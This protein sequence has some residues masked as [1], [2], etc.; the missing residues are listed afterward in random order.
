MP[1]KSLLFNPQE[2]KRFYY[3]IL[4]LENYSLE[5]INQ[6]QTGGKHIL[7]DIN[8]HYYRSRESGM[9]E[10]YRRMSLYMKYAEK[11]GIIH[12]KSNPITKII[13]PDR[14]NIGFA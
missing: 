5:K 3:D 4:G 8:T 10:S 11:L 13:N 14:F 2:L 7:P 6:L 1:S 12:D 9:E